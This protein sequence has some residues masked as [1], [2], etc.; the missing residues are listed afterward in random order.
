M[1][2]ALPVICFVLLIVSLFGVIKAFS[3]PPQISVT[4]EISLLDYRQQGK[5]DYRVTV[6]PS[7]LYGPE[8]ASPVPSLPEVMKYPIESINR[9]VLNFAYRFV[10]VQ[11]LSE[12][13]YEDIEIIGVLRQANQS[14]TKQVVLLPRT[15][16]T[17][18]ALVTVPIS[19]ADNSTDNYLDF[20]NGDTGYEMIITAYVYTAFMADA[21]L[22]FESFTQSLPF[23]ARGPMLEVNGELTHAA[24]ANIGDFNYQQQGQ[25]SYQIYFKP[26][27]PFGETVLDSPSLPV[28]APSPAL[29]LLTSNDVIVNSLIENMDMDFSYDLVSSKEIKNL[30]ETATLEV[31]LENP[32]KWSKSFK[33]VP[34]ESHSGKF[35]ISFPVDLDNYSEFFRTIQEEIG[36][37]ANV[38]NLTIKATVHAK[39]DTDYAPVSTD[40]IHSI[41]TDL[42]ADILSWSA[43]LTQVEPGQIK[44]N[45][46][47]QQPKKFLWIPISQLRVISLVAT[48]IL[49]PLLVLFVI[50]Y[51]VNRN[52]I[53]VAARTV[54]E[55][56][57][58]HKGMIVEVKGIPDIAFGETLVKVD[59]LDDL[60]K[61]AENLMKPVLHQFGGNEH[62]YYVFD[63]GVRYEYRAQ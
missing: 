8:P 7:H 57:N 49:F 29:T 43:N 2:I 46:I 30:E 21:K 4:K 42:S 39:A 28:P 40:F 58:R 33:V 27:S 52:K 15:R 14:D 63:A 34:L 10:T 38:R 61:T 50:R 5:F 25:F 35:T 12:N 56:H 31:I 41:T 19:L 62:I 60:V 37:G 53:P 16:Y 54:I 36:G 47:I 11:P 17:G 18:D 45:Q 23:T 48:I 44:A 20:S 55:A 1:K 22:V 13:A 24:S 51:M 32:G 3:S 9:I 6:K 59:S 26:S